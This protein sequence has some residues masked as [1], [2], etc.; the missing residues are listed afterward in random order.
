MNIMAN[1]MKS[2]HGHHGKA[3]GKRNAP[4]ANANLYKNNP[5]RYGT[6]ARTLKKG[7]TERKRRRNGLPFNIWHRKI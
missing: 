5:K 6:G 2:R 3:F 7:R 4:Y 1:L